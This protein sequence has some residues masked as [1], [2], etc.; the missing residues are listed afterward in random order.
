[1]KKTTWM[2]WLLIFTAALFIGGCSS[3]DDDGPSGPSGDNPPEMGG[4]GVNI[5]VPAGMAN[6]QD[7]HAQIANGYIQMAN[8]ISD[9][10][11][12]FTP[13]S[14][15]RAA[16]ESW[17]YSWSEGGLT[18]TLIIE[19]TSNMYTW[20]VYL[21]GSDGYYTYDNAHMYHAWE[22]IDG[23]CGGLEFY[24]LDEY[25]GELEWTWCTDSAGV[26]TMTMTTYYEL[27]SFEIELVVYPDG[28]GDLS[29]TFDGILE[30]YIE[31]NADGSGSWWTYNPADSGNWDAAAN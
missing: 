23:S 12:F 16:A 28:S 10:G 20:D 7:P 6:S 15:I 18:V 11:G 13:P 31:W 9:H 21:D 3:S 24:S 17:E 29:Y 27:E 5:T 30:L 4:T 25:M 2:A 14:G 22:Y 19:E 1:M 26:F 8:S